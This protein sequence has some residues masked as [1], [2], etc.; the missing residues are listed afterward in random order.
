MPSLIDS[1]GSIISGIF[2]SIVAVFQAIIN[3][4][5]DVSQTLIQA[6]GTMISGL[7][8]TF[9]GLLKFVLSE[10]SS[11]LA[12]ILQMVNGTQ[13][14]LWLLE[15]SLARSFCILSTSSAMDARSPRLLLERRRSTRQVVGH[16][17]KEIM[18]WLYEKEREGLATGTEMI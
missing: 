4:I 16:D 3:T 12:H 13:A 1:I 5:L 9:E 17:V 7:A 2:G 15:L 6:V 14:T 11:L 18:G 8:Q 10:F